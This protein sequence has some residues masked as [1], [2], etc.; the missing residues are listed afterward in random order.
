MRSILN[1]SPANLN[2]ADDV[3]LRRVD[4][5]VE[6]QILSFH[7]Q[8]RDDE[9]RDD[10]HRDDEHREDEHRED[11]HRDDDAALSLATGA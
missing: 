3:G 8:H 2:V 11:E 5:A 10:E 6:L 4:L 7:Q 9:H 1:F